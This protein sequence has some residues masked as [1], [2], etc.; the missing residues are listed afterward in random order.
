MLIKEGY[1][2]AD[3]TSRYYPIHIQIPAHA[4]AQHIRGYIRHP[5]YST[6]PLLELPVPPP[7]PYEPVLTMGPSLICL[8]IAFNQVISNPSFNAFYCRNP[9]HVS[10]IT[11]EDCSLLTRLGQSKTTLI[12]QLK[13]MD[14]LDAFSC[15]VTKT[16]AHYYC[17]HYSASK[18]TSSALGAESSIPISAS[19]CKEAIDSGSTSILGRTLEVTTLAGDNQLAFR[20]IGQITYTDDNVSCVGGTATLPT[21]QTVKG[22]LEFTKIKLTITPILLSTYKDKILHPGTTTPATAID[23]GYI[24]DGNIATIWTRPPQ[25]CKLM[26]VFNG[27]VEI[28]TKDKFPVIVINSLKAAFIQ[29]SSKP[30]S[31]PGCSG[32]F[33]KSSIKDV[34]IS[35]EATGTLTEIMPRDLHLD[36]QH[37]A[38]FTYLYEKWLL[39]SDKRQSRRSYTD[40]TLQ[41]G[42]NVRSTDLIQV[43]RNATSSTF[44]A[45][46]GDFLVEIHCPATTAIFRVTDTCY[47]ELPVLHESHP[48]FITP[49]TKT[50]TDI[51]T[52][53]P[54][55]P[56]N[57]V[58]LAQ[59][60][61]YYSATPRLRVQSPNTV[62][63]R[64][65]HVNELFSDDLVHQYKIWRK[66][67]TAFK[68]LIKTIHSSVANQASQPGSEVDFASIFDLPSLESNTLFSNP[69][70][71]LNNYATYTLCALAAVIS[72]V[73]LITKYYTALGQQESFFLKF[74]YVFC[75]PCAKLMA[76]RSVAS[77][78]EQVM[79][80]IL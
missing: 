24:L 32:Q 14:T 59:D 11:R 62:S 56:L 37:S 40:C 66:S 74:L 23:T 42:A 44:L 31:I 55:S 3:P 12:S 6:N 26:R 46:R 21:G 7:P 49:V 64:S 50:L 51:G 72:F 22:I 73:T 60:D 25:T 20:S 68:T 70:E 39:S 58:Y 48:M 1:K 80:E 53:I 33:Y 30:Q 28:H 65:P 79:M 61:L 41:A 35:Y 8:L 19:Q 38:K 2:Q 47:T 67:A 13:T 52:A 34:W 63:P 9:T 5:T 15:S 17:G 57:P 69:F 76:A 71:Y 77:G 29:K 75:H 16:V 78:P 10:S 54:C 18:T 45:N 4:T 27:S 43:A 36:I